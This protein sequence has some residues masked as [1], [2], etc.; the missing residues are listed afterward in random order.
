MPSWLLPLAIGVA[1]GWFVLP[2]L[3]GLI[4]GKKA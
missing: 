4:M 3:L 1:L 2:T